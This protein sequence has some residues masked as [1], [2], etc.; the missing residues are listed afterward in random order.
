MVELV[1]VVGIVCVVVSLGMPG[2]R[3]LIERLELKGAARQIMGDLMWARA[4]AVSHGNKFKVVLVGDHKYQILDDD[5]NDG[6]ADSGEW[7]EIRD[8]W[9]NYPHVR[10][11]CTADP[12]FFPRGSASVGTITLTNKSGVKKVKIHLTGRVKVA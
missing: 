9:D 8:I 12:V 11:S 2:L 3:G 4:Q 7:Y 10:M 6:R 5:D 1:I